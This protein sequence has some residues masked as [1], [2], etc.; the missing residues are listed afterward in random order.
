VSSPLPAALSPEEVTALRRQERKQFKIARAL[1]A[2]AT[3]EAAEREFLAKTAAAEGAV[4]EEDPSGM[5]LEE[6]EIARPKRPANG[7][8]V[9]P[10]PSADAKG[11]AREND[12]EIREDEIVNFEHLQVLP[13][14]VWF[15]AW[16][17]GCLTVYLPN[18]V[19]LPLASTPTAVRG[20]GLTSSWPLRSV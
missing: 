20:R 18:E 11:K 19:C 1:H 15:L 7:M 8:I 5:T 6:L 14:E 2:V 9:A 13:E 17:L 10:P 3:V 12:G 16:A 4:V